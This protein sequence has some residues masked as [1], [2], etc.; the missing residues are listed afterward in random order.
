MKNSFKN[1]LNLLVLLGFMV[2]A[3]ATSREELPLEA[4]NMEVAYNADSTGFLLKNLDTVDYNIGRA[5]VDRKNFNNTDST[6]AFA[7][8][9]NNISI[10]A[11]E[12]L[13]LPLGIFIGSSRIGA[14]TLS[15][16]VKLERF[17]YF[18]NL[19]SG[20]SGLFDHTF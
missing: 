6:T 5:R 20:V 3:W 10:K 4:I 18:A 17:L 2:L 9:L 8:L 11:N 7:F 13:T 15:K 19:P 12:T 1:V 14:D 16:N